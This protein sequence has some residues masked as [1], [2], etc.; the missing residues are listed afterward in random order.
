MSVSRATVLR[1]LASLLLAA[2]LSAVLTSVQGLNATV[3]LLALT[4]G[5]LLFLTL[6]SRAHARAQGRDLR[7]L[8]RS[9]EK[10]PSARA[11]MERLADM[12][13][14]L[15]ASEERIRASVGRLSDEISA[16]APRIAHLQDQIRHVGGSVEAARRSQSVELERGLRHTYQ[17]LEADRQLRDV[18]RPALTV[19]PSRGWAAS[20][21]LLLTL[22]ELIRTRRT[23]LIVECGSGAS[24]LWMALA[25]RRFDVE[26]RIV[27]LEH[28]QDFATKTRQLLVDHGVDDIVDVRYAPL[29]EQQIGDDTYLWYETDQWISL[30]GIELLLIDGPPASTGEFARYPAVP[31]LIDRVS[32]EVTILLDDLVR[33]E[34]K[35]TLE[36]WLNENPTLSA[37]TLPLEKGCAQIRLSRCEAGGG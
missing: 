12:D 27:S 32:P 2:A 9:I 25:M 34:E 17:Q 13:R 7:S 29:V 31:L 3:T 24:S 23:S 30:T 18:I 5:S 20:P 22:V 19:P 15:L 6:Q 4:L 8:H 11:M 37:T 35:Q 28:D 26:G 1:L 33:S 21:D 16:V 14:R 10:D 36:R